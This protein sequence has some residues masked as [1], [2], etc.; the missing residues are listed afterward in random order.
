MPA[1]KTLRLRLLKSSDVTTG[2]LIGLSLSLSL[3]LL[4]PGPS[5]HVDRQFSISF[6]SMEEGGVAY[7]GNRKDFPARDEGGEHFLNS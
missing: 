1:A 4:L 5:L 6:F 3:F 2:T 7:Q